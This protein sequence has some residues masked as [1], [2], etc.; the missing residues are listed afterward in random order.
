MVTST[1]T[2]VTVSVEEL[3]ELT[4]IALRGI[5]A[6]REYYLAMCPLRFLGRLFLFDEQDLAPEV[7]AQRTLNRARVPEIARY[8]VGNATTYCFSAICASIDSDVVFQPLAPDRDR[9]NVGRLVVPMTARILVNDGQHRRAALGEALRERPELG[10]ESIAVVFFVDGGLA[11]SQQMFADLN[12][13]AIR[14]TKSLGI[15]YDHRDP[16]SQLACKLASSVPVFRG[17]TDLEKTTISNRSRKLFTL[18]SIYLATKRLLRKGTKA[19]PTEAEAE[20]A[21][22]FWTE[23]GRHMPDWQDAVHRRVAAAELRR[24]CVHAHGVALQ[25]IGVA[26]AQLLAQDPARWKQRIKSLRKMDWTRANTGLWEGK[27]MV[28]G[29]VS[30]AESNIQLTAGVIERALGLGETRGME[31]AHV[32]AGNA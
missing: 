27:A 11:R 13:H 8:V 32:Q 7:R 2:E 9:Y 12:R 10:D 5:Q 24:D 1:W 29:R 23:I 14:P 16:M 3:G 31:S 6:G 22:A 26:G 4:F 21:A 30:K 17:M 28:N 19:S 15:L 18:S 20:L 25:A